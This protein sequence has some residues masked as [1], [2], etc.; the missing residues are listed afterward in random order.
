[1]GHGYRRGKARAEPRSKRNRKLIG[2]W[3]D[4]ECG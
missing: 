1:M 2:G 3:M 4:G